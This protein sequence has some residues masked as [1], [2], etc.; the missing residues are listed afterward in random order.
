MLTA[1]APRLEGRSALKKFR[2]SVNGK[3]FVV[4][5]EELAGSQAGQVAAA[6]ESPVQSAAQPAP[7]PAYNAGS[8]E[9]REIKAPLRGQTMRVEVQ[10]G[11][12]VNRGQLLLTIEALKLENEIVSPVGGTVTGIFTKPGALVETGDVLM[13]IKEE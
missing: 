13:T 10:Q 6:A 9:G 1:S 5:V 11:T 12:R 7:A 3:E 4:E 2:V 8:A